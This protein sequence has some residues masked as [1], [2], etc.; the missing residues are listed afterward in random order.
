MSGFKEVHGTYKDQHDVEVCI[1][2]P[3]VVGVIFSRHLLVY[4]VEHKTGVFALGGWEERFRVVLGTTSAQK[5]V[6]ETM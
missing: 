1:A 6:A 4:R 5:P 3:G 2:R